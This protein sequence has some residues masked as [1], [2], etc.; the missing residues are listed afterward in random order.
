MKET[1]L[2]SEVKHEWPHIPKL[3]WE[4][5]YW[6][7]SNTNI[8]TFTFF[9]FVLI[10]SVIAKKSLYNE[11][12]KLRIAILDILSKLN[13]NVKWTFH[14]RDFTLKYF[15]IIAWLA[16]IVLF[17]NI[18]WL[19]IDWIWFI[20]PVFLTYYRPINSDLNTTLVLAL[21]TVV[22]FL[23]ITFKYN[24]FLHTMKGYL[25]NF[26][27]WNFMEKIINLLIGWLHFVSIPVTLASLSLRLFGNIFAWVVLLSV[28][29]YLWWMVSAFVW[30]NYITVF[31]IISLPFWFF[32]IFVAFIQ[33]VI[34]MWLTIS[35]FEQNKASH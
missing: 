34:F 14:D 20:S 9:I 4:Q 25:F 28:I 15:P 32:E 7:I 10:F 23:W 21:V 22:S 18:F 33:T 8:A 19:I 11:K 1:Q 2:N 6:P 16:F 12:S 5:V 26:T 3:Q 17:W 27:W 30:D 13:W 35:Y 24:W 29:T 31:N